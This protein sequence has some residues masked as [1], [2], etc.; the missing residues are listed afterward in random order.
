MGTAAITANA[1]AEKLKKER[2]AA[3]VCHIRPDGDTLCSAA[4]LCAALKKIGVQAEVYC[5]DKVPEKFFFLPALKDVKDKLSG[6]YSA[7]IAMDCAEMTRLGGF[8]SAF[9]AHK[10]TYSI[11]HHISNTRFAKVNFVRDCA[12]NCEN[13]LEVILSLGITPDAEIAALLL[14]GIVTDTGSFRHK[15]VTPATMRT[16]A[17]LMERG[18]DLNLITYNAFT[19]QSKERAELFGRVIRG[20]R[21]FAGGKIALLSVLKEDFIKTGAGQDETEGFTD[22][23]MSIRGVDVGVCIMETGGKFKVSFRSRKTDV[24][25]VAGVFGGGGH[26]LASGCQISGEYEEAVDRIVCAVKRFLEE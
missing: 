12:A 25:A 11:D 13:A 7:L 14:T 19:A 2:R 15:N 18:A 21:F 24:N 3:L 16:A 23:A 26:T 1:L 20:I 22:F 10:N 17:Y 8:G 9:S 6:E 4:A 5:S